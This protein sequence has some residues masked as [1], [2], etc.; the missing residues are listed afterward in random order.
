MSSNQSEEVLVSR[1][2]A[3]FLVGTLVA[4]Y[5]GI[6]LCRKNLSVAVPLIQDAFKVGKADVGIVASVSTLAYL[7][8]KLLLC[9]LVDRVGG[10]TGFLV[11]LVLVAVFGALGALAPSLFALTVVYSLNRFFGAAG[12]GA[13]VKMV[14]DWFPS[15]SMAVAMGV[16][17]LSFVVGGVLASMLAGLI[18][19]HFHTW[20]AVMGLPSVVLLGL[21]VVAA[22][23]LPKRA[24]VTT[25]E[26]KV[27]E[28][29]A[30]WDQY[31]RLFANGQFLV[32]C[33]LS[34]TLTL[35]RET[36]NTWT[37]DYLHTLD[38]GG[39]VS[40]AAFLSTLF[41]GLGIVGILGMGWL[42]GRL[43]PGQ[44]RWTLCGIL[45]ALGAVLASLPALG[46][47]GI[48]WA[49]GAVGLVG[50]LVYGPYSLLAGVLSVEVQGKEQAATVSGLVDAA[51][52]LAG[53][54]SGWGFGRLV[55]LHGYNTGMRALALLMVL[56][57]GLCLL[58]FRRKADGEHPA[59]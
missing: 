18:V 6:Y 12:W 28:P 34:F 25:G 33:A 1:P 35:M 26:E 38:P 32:V 16:L 40:N 45:L 10:R 51:G 24:P 49:A 58:L 27:A 4:G 57:G 41:D 50:L 43:G 56:S 11:S 31:F 39:R 5:I 17:S 29:K 46:A 21:V 54:V 36:F 2:R 9:P 48:V 30:S 22:V 15:R 8:G 55:D 19:R 59:R 52:Y 14:P 42:Y 3:W 44:R 7:A 53:V 20:Q 13:M 37:V 47:M 23:I